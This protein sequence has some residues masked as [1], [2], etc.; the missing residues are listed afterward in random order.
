MSRTG[1]MKSYHG[2][3]KTPTFSY[4]LR[5]YST[6]HAHTQM[7]NNNFN[8][9]F[10]KNMNFKLKKGRAKWCHLLKALEQLL[11]SILV[12]SYSRSIPNNAFGHPLRLKKAY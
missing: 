1:Q 2:T 8:K 9:N 4:E 11:P 7:A 6:S 5:S 3:Q 10:G 12:Y